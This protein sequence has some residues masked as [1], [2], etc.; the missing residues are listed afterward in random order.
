PGCRSATGVARDP[1]RG[2]D[3]ATG[4]VGRHG[5]GHGGRAGFAGIRQARGVACGGIAVDRR[6]ACHRST[7]AGGAPC[8]GTGCIAGAVSGGVFTGQCSVL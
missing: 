4:L 5:L 8:T 7:P 2:T 1:G 3:L 6:A